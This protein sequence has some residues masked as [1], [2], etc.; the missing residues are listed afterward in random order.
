MSIRFAQGTS[1]ATT[2][3]TAQVGK[4][5]PPQSNSM[6]GMPG[7]L[8][9]KQDPSSSGLTGRVGGGKSAKSADVKSFGPHR[10]GAVPSRK[11]TGVDTR[12]NWQ[13]TAGKGGSTDKSYHASSTASPATIAS[14]KGT[15]EPRKAVDQRES[16]SRKSTSAGFKNLTATNAKF[17]PSGAGHPGRMESLRGKARTSWE[18]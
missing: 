17:G 7:F 18:K 1:L 9:T 5:A 10:E 3:K 2:K 6:K 12:A 13:K 8:K 16:G 4:V 14:N 11:A 15:P